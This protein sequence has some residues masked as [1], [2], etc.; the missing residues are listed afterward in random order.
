MDTNQLETAAKLIFG[1][2]RN[3][4]ELCPHDYEWKGYKIDMV[5]GD[6]KRKSV[7]V[8][9]ICGHREGDSVRNNGGNT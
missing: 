8:C 2:C 3:H 7:Y 1:L 5:D 6:E 9:R 4:P